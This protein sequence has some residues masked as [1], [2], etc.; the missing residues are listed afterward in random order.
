MKLTAAAAAGYAGTAS[1]ACVVNPAN[2]KTGA[3]WTTTFTGTMC[4]RT[5]GL[6]HKLV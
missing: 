1:V 4:T 3:D 5:T 6:R 2:T